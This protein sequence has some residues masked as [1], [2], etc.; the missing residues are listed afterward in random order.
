MRIQVTQ[1]DIE[2]GCR[3]VAENCPIA[4]AVIRATGIPY[5]WVCTVFIAVYAT[6]EDRDDIEHY[7]SKSLKHWVTPED[8]AKRIKLYDATGHMNPFEFEL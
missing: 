1:D 3:A 4:R 8:A 7:Q 5:A 2:Q 6:D